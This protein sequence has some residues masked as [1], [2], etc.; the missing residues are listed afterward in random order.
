MISNNINNNSNNLNL[1]KWMKLIT[2][3]MKLLKEI[4]SEIDNNNFHKIIM[5]SHSNNISNGS[6]RIIT[7]QF[8]SKISNSNNNSYHR[9]DFNLIILLVSLILITIICNPT[10]VLI[11]YMI[12]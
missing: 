2:I 3:I 7:S 8:Y 6:L 9:K 10:K 5:F 12:Q 4:P 11:E 1:N